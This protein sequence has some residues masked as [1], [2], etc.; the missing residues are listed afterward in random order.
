VIVSEDRKK[1]NAIGK[2]IKEIDILAN[3]TDK[4]R[5]VMVQRLKDVLADIRSASRKL[6]E[7]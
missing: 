2:F 6:K 5:K 4:R 7:I 1:L 3:S